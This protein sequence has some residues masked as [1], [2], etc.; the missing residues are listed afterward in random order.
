MPRLADKLE[1]LSLVVVSNTFALP[2][3]QPDKRVKLRDRHRTPVYRYLSPQQHS[4]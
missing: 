4:P 2:G 3:W 1:G